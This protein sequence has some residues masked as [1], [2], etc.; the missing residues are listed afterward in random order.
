MR[1]I[2]PLKSGEYLGS[3]RGAQQ[4]G[5]KDAESVERAEEWGSMA[6]FQKHIVMPLGT[7][8]LT[9]C[10]SFSYNTTA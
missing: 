2:K 4:R 10:A 8:R 6:G 3:D 1:D 9:I 5:A 7:K